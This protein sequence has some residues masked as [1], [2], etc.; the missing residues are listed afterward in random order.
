M[1]LA[2]LL[3][4]ATAAV[5]S[6][7]RES[8][9]PATSCLVLVTMVVAVAAA[10]DRAAG[11]LAALSSGLWFD[12]FL[13]RP[14]LSFTID[15]R[16][17]V[18]ITVLLVVIGAAVSELALWGRRQQERASLRAGYL[19]GAVRAAGLI[20]VHDRS[21]ED[22]GME[23]ADQIRSVLGVSDCRFVQ[24]GR[25]DPRNAV[26]EPDGTLIRDGHEVD[27]NRVGLPN[28]EET[29]LPI[30]GRPGI[31]GHFV[32][33]AVLPVYPTVEQRR[34]AALLA[35]QLGTVIDRRRAR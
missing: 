31:D 1:G 18:E 10:G 17:N 8:V 34:V 30:R 29:A 3:P 16:E 23:V 13:T 19:D 6:G 11:L 21:V 2:V 22:L 24:H 15:H 4:L 27:V 26:L 14:Y 7:A 33:T 35:D 28:L 5:L 25:P 32:I 9:A 12:F 20:A